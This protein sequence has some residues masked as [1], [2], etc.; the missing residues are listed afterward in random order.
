M[1]A[2]PTA[3]TRINEGRKKYEKSVEK[4]VDNVNA[5][6]DHHLQ[7]MKTNL[8][9]SNKS[10]QEIT[11]KNEK[12]AKN[13]EKIEEKIGKVQKEREKFLERLETLRKNEKEATKRFKNMEEMILQAENDSYQM[14]AQITRIATKKQDMSEKLVK[15]DKELE[16]ILTKNE[17]LKKA[18]EDLKQ[19][20]VHQESKNA[21]FLNE[22]QSYERQ[23]EDL[24]EKIGLELEK[25]Q[26]RKENSEQHT[27]L[28]NRKEVEVL[29]NE[30][31]EES[32]REDI[33]SKGRRS[34]SL[35]RI[36]EIRSSASSSGKSEMS[37]TSQPEETPHTDVDTYARFQ[38]AKAND[39]REHLLEQKNSLQAELEKEDEAI[40]HL[41]SQLNLIKLQSQEEKKS[42]RQEKQL[43]A[44]NDVAKAEL[45]N[46]RSKAR[47]LNQ[48]IMQLSGANDKEI[49]AKRIVLRKLKAKHH[50]AWMTLNALQKKLQLRV[51]QRDDAVDRARSVANLSTNVRN[52]RQ[53]EIVKLNRNIQEKERLLGLKG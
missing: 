40:S 39:L 36:T 1:I 22:I 37:K 29:Y 13:N 6:L 41:Q 47:E 52:D 8:F 14:K 38:L 48:K 23:V 34:Q 45:N 35:P 31:E 51:N 3:S 21:R 30:E 12:L 53:R 16:K 5:Q 18:L 28:K 15:T 11:T 32:D 10:L 20:E 24:R 50:E 46:L 25:K 4:H 42:E 7:L 19:N 43:S 27:L 17:D 2:A 9:D 33:F 49:E 44:N 26:I